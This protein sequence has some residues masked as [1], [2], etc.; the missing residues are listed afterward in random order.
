MRESTHRPSE[1]V[2]SAKIEKERT[3]N[4]TGETF[5]QITRSY[6]RVP[7]I[8][9]SSLLSESLAQ[10]H[11]LLIYLCFFFLYLFFLQLFLPLPDSYRVQ[12]TP[13]WQWRNLFF[14]RARFSEKLQRKCTSK[15]YRKSQ[16]D[17]SFWFVQNSEVKPLACGS[18]FHLSSHV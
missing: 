13:A 11:Y 12:T 9:A 17:N 16:I 3:R 5:S 4:K 6:F 18:W 1:I 8:Y 10:A 14:S 2:G 7:Y 15:C